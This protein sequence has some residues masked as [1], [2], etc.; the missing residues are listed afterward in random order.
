MIVM[1]EHLLSGKITK[2]YP[3]W[4]LEIVVMVED[5]MKLFSKREP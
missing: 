4:Y 1:K 5:N 2:V 3:T